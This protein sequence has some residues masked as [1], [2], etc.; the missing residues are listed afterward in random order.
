MST[1][2][3]PQLVDR[4]FGYGTGALSPDC[5]Q[6]LLSMPKNA[7]SYLLHWTGRHGWNTAII[8]DECSWDRVQEM[9][10]VL[11]DPLGRWVSGISQYINTYILNVEGPNGPVYDTE[12]KTLYDYSMTADHW[13]DNYNQNVERI[14]FDLISRFDDH[15]WPQCELFE[16][17][18]PGVQR[19]YF[20]LDSEFDATIGQYLNFRPY[21][22]INR[23]QGTSNKNIQKLQEFF[24]HRLNI[25][26]ELKQR[27]RNAYARDYELIK[28][29]FNQ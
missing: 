15:T 16:N 29:V 19:R 1:Q 21:D 7:S 6:F 25:R 5:S 14:I 22:N 27:V 9:I 26:P 12:N 4:R 10:V 28:Q 8:G 18:L 2:V 23:N 20:Y 24:Q 13:I 11:R 17:L 3:I